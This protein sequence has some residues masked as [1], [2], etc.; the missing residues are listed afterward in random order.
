L[1][2]AAHCRYDPA[3]MGKL[4]THVLDISSGLPAAGIRIDPHREG[5]A[6]GAG[7]FSSGL[8]TL[9]SISHVRVNIHPDGGLARVRLF[10]RRSL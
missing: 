6:D 2:L 7:P 4:T 1:Q 8:R 10:G 9:G 5:S 3:Q